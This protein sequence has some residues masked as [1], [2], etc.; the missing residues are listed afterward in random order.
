MQRKWLI[1]RVELKVK[2]ELDIWKKNAAVSRR[3]INDWTGGRIAEDQE[4][5]QRGAHDCWSQ[6]VE[7]DGALLGLHAPVEE[8]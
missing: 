5:K 8:L 6:K 7:K 1:L 4:L 3:S 2:E